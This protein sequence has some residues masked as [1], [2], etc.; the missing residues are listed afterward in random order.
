MMGEGE[1]DGNGGGERKRRRRADDGSEEPYAVRNIWQTL[2]ITQA[3]PVQPALGASISASDA[4]YDPT[5]PFPAS[6]PMLPRARR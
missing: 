2:S 5:S 1:A 6:Y 4:D 3:L